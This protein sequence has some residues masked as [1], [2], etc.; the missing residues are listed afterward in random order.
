MGADDG[1]PQ[2][3]A[4]A[5]DN[6]MSRGDEPPA[7]SSAFRANEE[8][9]AEGGE[10]EG[11]EGHERAECGFSRRRPPL[12]SQSAGSSDLSGAIQILRQVNGRSR[13]VDGDGDQPPHFHN[14][15]AAGTADATT[16]EPGSIFLGELPSVA[17]TGGSAESADLAAARN[18]QQQLMA[19]G[20]ERPEGD[21]CPICF[22]PIEFPINDHSRSNACCMK[23]V[24]DGCILAAHQRRM[25]DRCPFCRTPLPANDAS[26]LLA[27]I[28]TRVVKKDAEAIRH[29]GD[30]HYFGRLGLAK[31]VPRAIE[32]W[33]EAAELGSV[34]A[35]HDLG[36]VYYT[37]NGVEEDQPRAIRHL[38]EAAMKGHVLSR[39][40]LGV[41][42]LKVAGNCDLAVQ[43]WMIS[44]KMGYEGSL[45]AIKEIFKVGEAT[46]AQYAEA[47]LGYRDAVE[48]TKSPQRQEAKRLGL[49]FRTTF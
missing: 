32:L 7:A 2:S 5:A 22:L 40:G 31:D 44:A 28:Q 33:T 23:K 4:A 20:H 38:Q 47:L 6:G 46:K 18:H 3:I 10:G 9:A 13:S 14:G 37:G 24:C 36:I 48:E 17:P 42:E 1:H 11:A 49:D 21:W 15:I 35:H 29:L 27:M 41:D 34:D 26:T 30:K 45:N 19:S 12:Q 43:H 16:R 25:F 8:T 39:H